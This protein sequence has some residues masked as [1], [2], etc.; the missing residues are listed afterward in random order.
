MATLGPLIGRGRTADI[1]AW[2]SGRAIKLF[3]VGRSRTPIEREFRATS[4]AHERGCPA[5]RVWSVETVADRIGIVL[6]RL[7]G[8]SLTERLLRRPWSL[9]AGADL[10][11][12]LQRDIH[13]CSG[14]GLPAFSERAAEA[15]G[16]ATALSGEQRSRILSL[17][18][19]LP[20][21]D[22]VCH[23]DLHPENVILTKLGPVVI[24]W[25]NASCGNPL[26]DVARTLVLVR[27]SAL[28]AQWGP[29]QRRFATVFR[30]VFAGQYLRRC[31]ALAPHDREEY[32]IWMT[33]LLAHRLT[34]EIPAERAHLLAELIPRL[35]RL[36]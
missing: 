11:A 7:D 5:P 15:I 13:A 16:T 23:G 8:P 14:E 1:H 31:C 21:G 3:H 2:G 24:D 12:R 26:A 17:L 27:H 33:V 20:T 9:A 35:E 25:D 34:E 22:R 36:A 6:D 30:R 28:S 19:S 10:L 4:L 18:A 29:I 32:E